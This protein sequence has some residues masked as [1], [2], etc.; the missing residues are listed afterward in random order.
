MRRGL[1]LAVLVLAAC[2]G[3][4]PAPESAPEPDGPPASVG[5]PGPMNVAEMCREKW[6]PDQSQRWA[7][8]LA[9]ESEALAEIQRMVVD[10]S[11]GAAVED[12]RHAVQTAWYMED[13]AARAVVSCDEE[14]GPP[15][16]TRMMTCI[17][18]QVEAAER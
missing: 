18:Q 10:L 6:P 15:Y 1:T 17:E 16:Y 4:E 12:Y 13:P 2:S 11:G 3:P 14:I 5:A 7:E 8:C 9:E